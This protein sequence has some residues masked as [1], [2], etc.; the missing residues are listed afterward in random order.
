M[1][2]TFREALKSLP[3]DVFRETLKSVPEK[4]R[5]AV[6]L[7]EVSG[8]SIGEAARISGCDI[9]IFRSRVRRGRRRV[10]KI[11]SIEDAGDFRLDMEKTNQTVNIYIDEAAGIKVIEPTRDDEPDPPR[12][13]EFLL[14]LVMPPS[15]ADAVTG[16]LNEHFA[17]DYKELGRRR[18]VRLYWARTLPSL[19][20]LLRRAIGKAMKWG[21]I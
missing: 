8:F 5:E 2:K 4:E 19:W 16:D 1:R 10:V 7:T 11:L 21:A 12:L 14:T 20:P 6:I 18:A 9:K 15:R 13:A 3:T 17:R